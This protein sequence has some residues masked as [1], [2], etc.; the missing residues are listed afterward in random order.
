LLLGRTRGVGVLALNFGGSLPEASLSIVNLSLPLK[1]RA[2][3]V[4]RNVDIGRHHGLSKREAR[5]HSTSKSARS[6]TYPLC[7]AAPVLSHLHDLLDEW[8]E[9][10]ELVQLA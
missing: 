10:R 8:N 6:L 7:F 2:S 4:V 9:M 3:V 5:P 1:E